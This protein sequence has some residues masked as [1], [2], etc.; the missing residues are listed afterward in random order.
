MDT[1]SHSPHHSPHLLR[2]MRSISRHSEVVANSFI[3][4]LILAIGLALGMTSANAQVYQWKD[5]SGKIHYGDSLPSSG[6]FDVRKLSN[7]PVHTQQDGYLSEGYSSEYPSDRELYQKELDER[8]Q[9]IEDDK[10]ARQQQ[11]QEA[12]ERQETQLQEERAANC[13]KAQS[14]LKAVQ[15]G[16]IRFKLDQEGKRVALDGA[17]RQEQIRELENHIS[18]LCN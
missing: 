15:D 4:T 7:I 16:V 13:E 18:N 11:Q 5:A 2:I 10:K 1:Y 3:L 17:V 14:Q 9:Q 8:L 6:T 12:A